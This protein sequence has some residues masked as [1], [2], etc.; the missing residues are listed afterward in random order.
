MQ[1]IDTDSALDEAL[2]APLFLLLKHSNRCSISTRAFAE[3]EKLHDARPDVP[4]GYIDVV[5]DRPLSLRAAEATGIEHASPQVLLLRDG[6]VVWHASHFDISE[7]AL[8][9]ALA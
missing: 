7:R 1:K 6:S 9:E 5:A 4:T 3:W 2:A 8:R